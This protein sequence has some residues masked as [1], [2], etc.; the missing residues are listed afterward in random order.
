[1]VPKAITFTLV[2]HSKEN[3]QRELLQELY[4]PE[5]LDD[6]LKESEH[7]V[8]RRKEVMTTL[9]ALNKADEYVLVISSSIALVLIWSAESLLVCRR[10]T[11]LRNHPRHRQA[12]II[13]LLCVCPVLWRIDSP[14]RSRGAPFISSINIG[15]PAGVNYM[16]AQVQTLQKRE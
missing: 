8:A 11:T 6:M 2:N 1:M 13:S 10:T 16:R 12:V 9:V 4:K 7:V 5:I 3:L 15:D 14:V